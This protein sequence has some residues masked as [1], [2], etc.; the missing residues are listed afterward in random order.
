MLG[1]NK[2][3]K[4]A[5]SKADA[6]EPKA[7]VARRGETQVADGEQEVGAPEPRAINEAIDCELELQRN[8]Q[9]TKKEESNVG[10]LFTNF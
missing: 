2:K 6:A 4:N 9:G 7:K 10:D 3:Q 8:L 1:H 5:T